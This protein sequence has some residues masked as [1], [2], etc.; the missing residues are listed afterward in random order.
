MPRS[1]QPA[2]DTAVET[3]ATETTE[4][5]FSEAIGVEY[6]QYR[7]KGP[8]AYFG[9]AA[10]REGDQV[11]ASHP[12]VPLWLAD[13]SIERVQPQIPQ[14]A[15]GGLVQARPGGTIAAAPGVVETTEP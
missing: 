2:A 9:A 13:G 10:F 11:P 4:P 7:A 1:E 5:T 8:L 6:R 15:A 12:G 14:L 3:T